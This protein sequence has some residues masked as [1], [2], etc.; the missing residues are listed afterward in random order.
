MSGI[1]LSA[2]QG[3]DSR[4]MDN[5]L[6]KWVFGSG[7]LITL[8][9]YLLK[10]KEGSRSATLTEIESLNERLS[11]EISRLDARLTRA[12][13]VAS[14]AE[15]KAEILENENEKLIEENTWYRGRVEKLEAR[16]DELEK[17]LEIEREKL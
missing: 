1:S 11:N 12:E 2:C 4:A 7:G 5:E 16:V 15:E 6:W 3:G 13:L 14:E 17:D 10:N 9:G 8:V